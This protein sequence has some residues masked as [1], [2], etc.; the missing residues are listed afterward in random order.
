MAQRVHTPTTS[1]EDAMPKTCAR[2]LRPI[3]PSDPVVPVSVV[4]SRPNYACERCWTPQERRDAEN[5]P[6]WRSTGPYGV[7]HI[8]DS[9]DIAPGFPSDMG[10]SIEPTEY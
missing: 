7:L 2:C 9:D 4:R 6:E 1:L 8:T 3:Q 10:V 5:P